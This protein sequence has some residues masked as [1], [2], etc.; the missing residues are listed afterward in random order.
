MEI[1]E[2][3]YKDQIGFCEPGNIVR[4]AWLDDD[5]KAY[6]ETVQVRG[7]DF[8]HEGCIVTGFSEVNNSV[9]EFRMSDETEVEVL[10]G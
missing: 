8:D 3:L 7:I 6:I 4:F 9:D 5:N 1:Y 10:G 2:V